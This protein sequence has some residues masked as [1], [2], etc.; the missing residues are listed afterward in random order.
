MSCPRRPSSRIVPLRTTASFTSVAFSFAISAC[1]SSV[2]NALIAFRSCSTAEYTAACIMVGIF[3]M[4][5]K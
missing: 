3:F 5:S 4:R 1:A 2:P